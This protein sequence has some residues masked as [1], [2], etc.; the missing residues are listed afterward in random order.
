MKSRFST[1]S[2]LSGPGVPVSDGGCKIT[3]LA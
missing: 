1:A 2:F 3:S